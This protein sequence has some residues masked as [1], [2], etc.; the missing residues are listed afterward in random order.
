M[1]VKSSSPIVDAD[2]HV[3][4]SD[5]TWSYLAKSESH[6]RPMTLLAQDIPDEL[7][8]RIGGTLRYWNMGGT[9]HFR[10]EDVHDKFA[11]AGSLELK[12]MS[13]RLADMDRMKVD[14]QVIY[15]TMFLLMVLPDADW[16][17]AMARAYNR[18]IADCCSADP[19]RL[20]WVAVI[21]PRRVEA[22]LVELKRAKEAGAVG[23]MIRAFEDDAVLDDVRYEP[24]YRLANELDLPICV[25]AG[26]GSASFA[27]IKFGRYPSPNVVG[28]SGVSAL[29]ASC[30][31]V[32]GMPEKYTSLRIAF[33]E[34]ASYWVPFALNRSQR[35]A[36]RKLNRTLPDSAMR[37]ARIYVGVEEYEPLA[38]TKRVLSGDNLLLGT[39]YGHHTDTSAEMAA[40]ERILRHRDLDAD[41]ARK[42]VSDNAVRFYG[43]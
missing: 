40:H 33:L 11:T 21:E 9:L 6:Y 19:K 3:Y 30:W 4:E 39:D 12:D 37:D 34:T 17:M 24:I 10:A 2:T 20:R 41:T 22:S 38:E 25:H 42:I 18:W 35:F 7:R 23:V 16:Q 14:V 1:S 32:S 28:G 43:L 15:S 29:A 27:K 8:Q 26:N 31:L 13:L 5:A 36:A